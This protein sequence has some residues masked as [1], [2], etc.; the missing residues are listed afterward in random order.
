MPSS[1]NQ[2]VG[3]KAWYDGAIYNSK[4]HSW[5]DLPNDGLQVVVLYTNKRLRSDDGWCRRIWSGVDYYW[6]TPESGSEIFCGDENP[7]ERY[8]GA[9]I[10]RGKW[11]PLER[12]EKI[13][14]EA[15]A[16]LEF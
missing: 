12:Y 14:Q 15:N 8:P 9:I 7:T 16:S 11:I 2:I 6:T 1:G 10:K 4:E 5:K 3:W 13:R